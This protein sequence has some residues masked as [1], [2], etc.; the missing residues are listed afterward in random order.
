MDDST[1]LKMSLQ[2]ATISGHYSG[3]YMAK[4]IIKVESFENIQISVETASELEIQTPDTTV[5]ISDSSIETDLS[6]VSSPGSSIHVRLGS[7]FETSSLLTSQPAYHPRN[8]EH[9]VLVGT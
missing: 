7:V 6:A 8:N 4:V 9:T 5:L 2:L 3:H 1:R